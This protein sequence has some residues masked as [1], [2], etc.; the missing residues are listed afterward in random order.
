MKQVLNVARMGHPVL[1]QVAQAVDPQRIQSPE[2]QDFVD[3]M[4]LTMEE[5]DGVGLAAPQVHV[6]ERVVV[7]HEAAGLTGV[8]G[9]PLTALINPE[10]EVLGEEKGAMWRAA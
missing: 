10:I 8:D 4:I 9:E 7:F 3:S 1:R 2:F 5:Y 6:S